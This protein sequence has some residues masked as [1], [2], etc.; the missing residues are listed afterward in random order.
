MKKKIVILGSTGSI[1][2]TVLDVIKKDQKK[3]EIT[4]L[5]ANSNINKLLKQ[6]KIFNVKNLI[7]TNKTKY[8]YAKKKLIDKNVN[9]YNDFKS[10]N[11]I[12]KN[13]KIYYTMNAISGLIGLDPTLRIIKFTNKIAIANKESIICGWNLIKKKLDFYKTDFIPVD[14]EHFSIWSLI[15]K[16]N[17]G[18]IERVFITAS[19]G[20]F[21][22]LDLKKFKF[23]TRK[24]ALTH[25]NWKMGRKITIN[26]ATMMNKV[27]EVIE[28]KNIFNLQYNKISILVHPKSY[29][30]A[31]VKFHNGLTKILI[32][33]TNMTIPI[34]N[35]LYFNSQKKI[36]SKGLNIDLLN[37]LDFQGINFKKFPVT[38]IINTLPIKQSLFETVIVTAN[39]TLVDMFL[40]GKINFLDISKIL[41][42][43]I[44]NKDF[45]KYKKI[46]PKN[47]SQINQ[48][49]DYVRFKIDFLSI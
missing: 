40:K 8:N 28:A 44:K 42:K 13:K 4:L 30:H 17:I 39:D 3:F 49:S 27:F 45:V 48:I 47:I 41:L 2:K 36:K 31:I 43:I 19:G 38:K 5:T 33:D 9:I 20:P 14:S 25:P 6:A 24:K 15:N 7:I 32:H 22:K 26:S 37:N 10:I 11:K 35:S 46:K 12:L 18:N 21:N 29:V 16:H 34:F 1:G 23:I